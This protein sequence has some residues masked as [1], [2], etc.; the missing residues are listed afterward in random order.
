MLVWRGTL[1][2]IV[3]AWAAAFVAPPASSADA[4]AAA[5]GAKL[6]VQPGYADGNFRPGRPIP[7]RVKVTSDRLIRGDLQV[8][9]KAFGEGVPTVLPIEVAGGNPKEFVVVLPTM[10][11]TDRVEVVA[12]LA[13]TNVSAKA[14]FDDDTELVGLLPGVSEETPAPVP[15]AMDLGTMR[16]TR[17]D[18]A[19]LATPGGMGALGTIVAGPDGLS[20]VD[21]RVL[22]NLLAWIEAGGHLVV[23]SAVGDPVAGLPDAWQPGET[24]RVTAGHGQVRAAAGAVARGRWADVVAPTQVLRSGN[25]NMGQF[26]SDEVSY[27]LAQGS[28]L[29]LPGVTGLMVFLAVYV[30]VIGPVAFV[31]VRRTK[32][33]R[34]LG[35]VA[36]GGL[37]VVFT[38]WAFV[39]GRDLR[40]NTRAAHASYVETG[41][42]GT[43]SYSYLGL[44]S[45]SGTDPHVE[46]P[47]GWSAE[48]YVSPWDSQETSGLSE[49]ELGSDVTDGRM[50]LEAGGFGLMTASGAVPG[51]VEGLEVTA[52]ATADGSLVGKLRN[53]SDV[54]L[55]KVLVLVG[56]RSWDG[57]ELAPGEEV[58]WELKPDQ[59]K[60][61][62]SWSPPEGPWLDDIGFDDGMPNRASAIDYSVWAQTRFNL[63]DPYAP[64]WVRAAGWTD[65]WAPPVEVGERL[66]GKT[67]F[68]TSAPVTAAGGGF[69]SAAVQRE[70]L[71]ADND[72]DA[73]NNDMGFGAQLLLTR[74]TLPA[75]ADPSTPLEVV[76]GSPVSGYDVWDGD[77]WQE[78][79]CPDLAGDPD[80]MMNDEEE[81]NRCPLP[82]SAVRDGVV[83]VRVH[84]FEGMSVWPGIKVGAA[85]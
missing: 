20:G 73:P 27:S 28:G 71:R 43:R 75:G 69:P 10:I 32:R 38:A 50:G 60:P 85:R 51:R 36:I 63:V 3:V 68:T 77:S 26:M 78:V 24:G 70:V 22:A 2:A 59:G 11:D 17:L 42:S 84:I 30:L 9:L 12:S 34:N 31:V 55:R 16:F 67:V 39:G 48:A 82:G 56:N 58:D 53:T 41:V 49:V 44:I 35:W 21:E 64:G 72:R 54:P 5:A 57:G 29:K 8:H 81:A 33:L 45:P 62:D 7:V 76:L 23:D 25:P 15:M 74:F 4:D 19:V 6:E 61:R 79:R 18:Q 46:M 47:A 40:S 52:A 1:A 14:H 83:Y 37:A 65:T 80:A 13:G 66:R